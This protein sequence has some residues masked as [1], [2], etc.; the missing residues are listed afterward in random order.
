MSLVA[1]SRWLGQKLPAIGLLWLLNSV[2][3][4][5]A[6]DIKYVFPA[7]AA[8]GAAVQ[9]TVGGN[10][11]GWPAQVWVDRPGIQIAAAEEQGKFA[12]TVAADAPPGVY[13]LRIYN[14]EGAAAPLPFIVG[15]LSE[16]NEEEPNDSPAKPQSLASSNRTVNGRLEKRGDVDTF[17]VPLVKGQ[18]LVAAVAAHETLGS[19]MDAVLQIVSPR[20]SVLAQSDDERGLDP[21]VTFAAPAD[22]LYLVRI[23]AFP[24]TPDASISL[25]GGETFVYRL[26]VTT[27]G[28]LDAALPLAA[29]RAPSTIEAFG[30]NISDTDKRLTLAPSADQTAVDLFLPQWAGAI[31][32]PVVDTPAL[33]ETEPNDLAHPQAI[34]LPASV[35]GRIAEDGDRDAFR[36][37]LAKGTTWRF[38]VDSRALG[39]PLDSV[40]RLVDGSGK[41]LATSDDAGKNIDAELNFT[42]PADG[43]YTLELSDLYEHSGGR[44]F[45]RLSLEPLGPDFSLSVAQHAYAV[46]LGK[47]LELPVT[48][49]R[50]Q[51]FS[52]EI[53][54]AVVGLP[55]GVTCSPVKSLAQGDTA[56]TVKLTFTGSAVFSGPIQIVGTAT[57]PTSRRHL[58]ETPLSLGA[59]T[60]DLWLTVV[61]P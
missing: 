60:S 19:P 21:L 13:W 58:A 3:W 25:A 36:V 11:G 53:E 59:R 2:T 61:K 31:S 14:A 1:T 18:M 39:Y 44:Y 4:A 12:V 57:E 38:K 20:G 43:N 5:A 47:T 17:A 9:V 10:P 55:D 16:A 45:Y 32:L 56:K 40:L 54:V 8:R 37:H 51:N 41:V 34:E 48:I 30:W 24:A 50:R 22:G 23:F 29:S 15:T 7:G 46:G 49:D 52:G 35:S 6:P 28:F 27:G 42:A 33:C 26:T